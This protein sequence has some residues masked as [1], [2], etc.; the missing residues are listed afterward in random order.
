MK[1]SAFVVSFVIL[2]LVIMGA[3]YTYDAGNKFAS[4][5]FA[6]FAVLYCVGWVMAWVEK[7]HEDRPQ[8]AD[9]W[10]CS[11]H[12]VCWCECDEAAQK[13]CGEFFEQCCTC[14]RDITPF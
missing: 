8:A 4:G 14:G 2:S 13:P 10:D 1:P 5:M 11:C 12:Q 9:E 7:P 3:L 6:M